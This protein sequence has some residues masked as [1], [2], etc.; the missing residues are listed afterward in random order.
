[1][2]IGGGEVAGRFLAVF[3]LGGSGLGGYYNHLV[4]LFRQFPGACFHYPFRSALVIR[5]V[6]VVYQSYFHRSFN[7]WF[8]FFCMVSRE[9]FSSAFFL[10]AWPIFL[11]ISGSVS[12]YLNFSAQ[13]FSRPAGTLKPSRSFWNTRLTPGKSEARTG[14]PQAMASINTKPK[15]SLLSVEGRTR[16]SLC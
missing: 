14:R 2:V 5:R 9:Y 8:N 15:A 12:R 6:E 10:A 13:S 1:M 11:L 4:A 3:G 16:I 7:I